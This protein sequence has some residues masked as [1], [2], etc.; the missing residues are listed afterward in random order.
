MPGSL[1]ASLQALSGVGSADERVL[2]IKDSVARAIE[3]S[4]PG[5]KVRKTEYFNHAAVPDLVVQWRSEEPNRLVYLRG[6]P[7]PRLLRQ[8]LDL[9]DSKTAI[10]LPLTSLPGQN[11]ES[12]NDLAQE[13]LDQVAR[14]RGTWILEP[15]VMD[16]LSLARVSTDSSASLISQALVRGGRGVTV[17]SSTDALITKVRAGFS[18]AQERDVASTADAVHVIRDTLDPRQA[19][20]MERVLR[21]VWEGSGGRSIDFPG[22]DSLGALS[23]DDLLYLVEN[24]ADESLDFWRRVGGA[25]SATQIARLHLPDVS[26]NLQFLVSANL[27]RLQVKALR[28]LREDV[29]LGEPEEYPRWRA[30]GRLSLRGAGW[31]VYV[32]PSK[33]EELPDTPEERPIA[34]TD[35]KERSRRSGVGVSELELA[36]DS[37]TVIYQSN[38]GSSVLGDSQLEDLVAELSAERVKAATFSP[39]PNG[40]AKIDFVKGQ[41]AGQTSATFAAGGLLRSG[42]GLLL[43]IPD[44][45]WRNL[46]NFLSRGL[47]ED[48]LSDEHD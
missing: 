18:G 5:A 16:T 27:E 25:V 47:Q 11:A 36:A 21:A 22:G 23:D 34:L 4:D 9:I 33:V 30:E 26:R 28:V 19:S 42:L 31:T 35:L 8:G 17:N 12:D 41:A 1:V 14:A 6:N 2:T 7:D 10:V 45:E 37:R 39:P 43:D 15:A 20:R 29:Y 48:L 44:D 38:D 32:A 46:L 40:T 13:E 3:E 24:V